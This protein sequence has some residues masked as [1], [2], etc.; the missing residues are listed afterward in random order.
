[1][2]GRTSFLEIQGQIFV[3]QDRV[4][5]RRLLKRLRDSEYSLLLRSRRRQSSDDRDRRTHERFSLQVPILVTPALFDGERIEAEAGALAIPAVT[6]DLTLRGVGF[7]HG[8]LLC[9]EYAII[10]CDLLNREGLGL[11]FSFRWSNVPECGLY[12][13][14]G[15]FEALVSTD[16]SS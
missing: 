13:S 3:R 8:E 16:P 6:T 15:R 7:T 2:E 14:G 11:L 1:M 4:H 5:I 9:A 12:L 10:T